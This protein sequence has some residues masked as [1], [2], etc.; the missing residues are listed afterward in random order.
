MQR[1]VKA[2]RRLISLLSVLAMMLGLLSMGAVTAQEVQNLDAW[3]CEHNDITQL[4]TANG[5]D[6]DGYYASGDITIVPG[7]ANGSA[8]ALKISGANSGNGQWF[9]NLKSGTDYQITF[10][11]KIENWGGAAYP[12]FGVNGYDGDA[13]K[14]VA[15]FSGQWK[16]YSIDFRTGASSNSACVYTWIFGSGEV[17]FYVDDVQI[18]EITNTE[19]DNSN[20]MK[21]WDFEHNDISILGTAN[22]SDADGYNAAGNLSIVPD[23]ANGS[24]YAL[25][26]SNANSGN[27]QWIYGLKPNTQYI[28]RFDAKIANW[29]GASYPNFGV[30]GYDGDA[31]VSAAQYTTQWASYSLTFTTGTGSTCAKVYT[32]IF[33]SGE[34]DF[35]VDNVVVKEFSK[36]EE[37]DNSNPLNKWNFEH[38]DIASLG[39]ASASDSDGYNAAGD[40]TIVPD[41]ANGTAYALKISGVDCSGNGLWL[42]DLEPNTDYQISFYA[43]ATNKDIGAYPN[44]GVTD[45]GG[46]T[47]TI[48]RFTGEW[49]R[50]TIDFTTGA[51][52]T[53]ARIYTWIFGE[54]YADFFI[55]EVRLT[56]IDKD[57]LKDWN[58][59]H[60]DISALGTYESTDSDGYNAAGKLSIVNDG[61]NGTNYSL[62]I[63]GVNSGNGQWIYGL[64]TNTEYVITYWAKIANRSNEAYPNLGVQHYGGN[65]QT[66]DQYTEQWKKYT[67]SF[68]TDNVTT[69]AHIYTWVFGSGNVDFY[70]DELTVTPKTDTVPGASN[71]DPWITDKAPVED[72]AYSFAIVGDTQKVTI[73]DV[74]NGTSDFAAIYDYLVDN[75]EQQKIQTVIG[76]GDIT[77]TNAE[78]EWALAK[79][80]I[81]KLDGKVPYILNRGN[82]DQSASFNEAFGGTA[83][84]SQLS[85]TYDGKL[86]NSYITFMVNNYRYL[87]L[88]LDLGANDDVLAWANQVVAD[89][90]DHNVI[91]TTHGYLNKDGSLLTA[92]NYDAPTYY[93]GY[94]NAD[95]MWNKLI[96]KHENIVLVLSGHI[97]SDNIVCT[98]ATGD[99]GNKIM[100]ML[101]NPQGVDAK[102]GST[103]MVAMFYFA[104]D[105]KTVQVEYYS[106]AKE[107]Y[108]LSANQFTFELDVVRKAEIESW[109][110]S[111][112]EDI[113]VNFYTRLDV[114]ERT[115]VQISVDGLKTVLDASDADVKD[116]LYVFTVNLAAAQMTEKINVEILIDDNTVLTGGYTV[117]QYA[118]YILAD[119]NNEFSYQTEV[120]VKAMLGYGGKAQT[121][122]GYNTQSMADAGIS[123]G[124]ESIPNSIP[125]VELSGNVDG[126]AFY[127]ASMLFQSKTALR[128]YF[129]VTGDIGRYTFKVGE[130]EYQAVAKDGM[131][132]VEIG[133]INPQDL[134]KTVVLTVSGTTDEMT[135]GYSPMHYIQRMYY[136][137]S[138]DELKGLL[139]AMYA[140]H[141]AARGYAGE[142]VT[143]AD[144]GVLKVLAIGN[145]FTDDTMDL[146]YP[147][148]R[149]LGVEHIE[150]G[151]LYIGNSKLDQHASNARNDAGAYEYRRIHNGEYSNTLSVSIGTALK[152]E[153]WDFVMLQQQSIQAGQ[154]SSFGNL[155]YLVAYIKDRVPQTTQL[156]WNMTW[157]Y[158]TSYS[159]SS[160]AIYDYDQMKMYDAIVATAQEVIVPNDNFAIL[161]PNGTAIQN[162]RTSYAV[163]NINR[164]AT[165]L[166]FNFGR[167]IAALTYVKMITGKSID[168]IVYAPEGLSAAEKQI[169]IESVNNAIA[170]PFAITQSVYTQKP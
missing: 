60:N 78:A 94:N 67:I 17:D 24:S 72:Y 76:L 88:A 43:K 147:I 82:H 2:A 51:S 71:N 153:N 84:E 38:N 1:N 44:F 96:R 97:I 121:Y 57:P 45:Y 3:N 30:N 63:T 4:G 39:T 170:N 104:E 75:L 162:A 64:D 141:I 151:Y 9:W 112:G 62:K 10:Y 59:E 161:I 125:E 118:Q 12:N 101:I 102:L 46:A 81:L 109:N 140:Y 123:I 155:D 167:Y 95:D 91:I 61:A 6:A 35:Y 150:V 33:G 21:N 86:D 90:P 130:K 111:L 41:G 158:H 16:Q 15:E 8:Y 133:D 143:I 144:D 160:F 132:Y 131:Y 113:G 11:A 89:H 70:I 52:S 103:G 47:K 105:G 114:P 129:R 85:G 166:S 42:Y 79:Q 146:V 48:A 159:D 156:V 29:S 53:K 120:L 107:A 136:G 124:N 152:E 108:Y 106:T 27:G 80:N 145:S 37:D 142:N 115:N 122:F 26:I 34:V 119:E 128:Y 73:A 83:Y 54:G 36:T 99:N 168:S 50:Y 23:G 20:L 49:A 169:A 77:D 68:C 137:N 18:K 139:Q 19:E 28:V 25:K 154:P 40:V 5:N 165:H 7:G 100:Q 134:D 92:D 58:F 127:G 55:D 56:E 14:S 22:G 157:A 98:Q 32:W 164:D 116:G 74:N 110:L 31:Y 65:A 13:Y 93:E 117:A 163:D 126:I 66:I 135:I 69:S 148:A 87:V 138:S 149:S